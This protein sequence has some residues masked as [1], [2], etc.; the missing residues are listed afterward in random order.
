MAERTPWS[1][2]GTWLLFIATVLLL[3]LPALFNRFPMIFPDTAAYLGVSYG[4]LWTLD[5]SAFYGLLFKPILMRGEPLAALWIALAVQIC[6]IA[7]VLV[8]AVRQI[9]PRI[10]PAGALAA[11]AVTVALTALPWHASQLMPDALTG[12]LVLVAW[13]AA[14]R[15]PAAPGA[16]LLWLGAGVL[17]L[18]HY[19]H[20]GVFVGAVL[21]TVGV[22]ALFGTSLKQ[23]GKRLLAAAVT[24]AAVVTAHVAA[25]GILFDRW[26]VS[27]M[28]PLFLFA[29]L[30]EDGQIPRWFER[31]CGRDAPRQLCD[32]RHQLP[33]DSQAL[34]WSADSALGPVIHHRVGQPESWPWID[35]LD[36]AV[37]GSLREEPL[38]FAA[39]SA[40]ATATQLVHFRALDD[41]CPQQCALAEL[42]KFRPTLA[43]RLQ[44][45][46][47]L[48]G[49]IPK[50]LVRAVTSSVAILS[51]LLFLLFLEVARR[52]KDPAA[53]ALL[54][55]LMGSLL[56]NAFMAGALSD[57]HDRYQSRVI[58]LLPF[59]ELLL[60]MRWG[61]LGRMWQPA[62]RKR[63]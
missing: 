34:L 51:L 19:T 35:M 33:R 60:A 30:H 21:C 45:S 42:L 47:Q 11:I 27:P 48:Q 2:G 31:H 3:A 41:E 32:I 50:P 6:A 10:T 22:L 24:V 44:A 56:A 7:A 49:E 53:V 28:G 43:P 25:H 29:R 39:N 62:A 63:R 54:V 59:A 23:A 1:A 9:V 18:M 52:K 55:A 17:C 46:R 58:W 38:T 13:L 14:M 5:R 57:V 4:D 26:S 20:L 40:R 12:A 36:Q 16:P 15:D 8:L 61:W 37:K